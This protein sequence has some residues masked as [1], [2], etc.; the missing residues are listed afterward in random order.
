MVEG[1]IRAGIV[2]SA[3]A[4]PVVNTIPSPATMKPT[5]DPAV[6]N[7]AGAQDVQDQP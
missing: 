6:A 3:E 5:V 2:T 7:Q 4:A 1:L